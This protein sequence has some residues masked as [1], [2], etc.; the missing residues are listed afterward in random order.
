MLRGLFRQ[1]G[2]SALCVRA[3]TL[4]YDL[5]VEKVRA[6]GQWDGASPLGEGPSKPLCWSCSSCSLIFTYCG[7]LLP[8]LVT[9]CYLVC[10]SLL[11]QR[12]GI[13]STFTLF[14]ANL[15]CRLSLL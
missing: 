11:L 6:V 13:K 4:L 3:V 1:P 7:L 5:F 15:P 9:I 12:M 2:S 8:F 10:V 14:I